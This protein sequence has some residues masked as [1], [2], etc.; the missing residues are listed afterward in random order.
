MDVAADLLP[1]K[2]EGQEGRAQIKVP[3]LAKK[4]SLPSEEAPVR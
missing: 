4:V 3:M 2:V 1:M